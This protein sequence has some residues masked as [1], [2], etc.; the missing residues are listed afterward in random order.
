MTTATAATVSRTDVSATDEI[1]AF[2][3]A[4]VR[5]AN[6][7]WLPP[8][9]RGGDH[10][11]ARPPLAHQSQAGLC[12][13][14]PTG[15]RQQHANVCRPPAPGR[16]RLLPGDTVKELEAIDVSRPEM[17]GAAHV[18]NL[19]GTAGR[20]HRLSAV[21]ERKRLPPQ[22]LPGCP[23]PPDPRLRS[24]GRGVADRLRTRRFAPPIAGLN[25]LAPKQLAP[26]RIPR[27]MVLCP[28]VRQPHQ[29]PDPHRRTDRSIV[30]PGKRG[31]IHPAP[32]P[33]GRRKGRSRQ[34]HK[35]TAQP[36]RQRRT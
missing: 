9:Q 16:K 12:R 32:V 28:D 8:D 36:T 2:F 15:R 21:G 4:D 35:R 11:L 13:P 27:R 31:S 10:P 5:R 29:G 6:P 17:P 20:C 25:A 33:A 7:K 34:D 22:P 14:R 18:N 30:Q 26:R 3:G 24:H 23:R 1:C 19:L